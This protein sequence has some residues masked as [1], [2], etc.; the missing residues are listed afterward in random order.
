[1]T[2]QVLVTGATGF[3]GANIVD[4]LLARGLR[5]RGATRSRAKGDAMIQARPQYAGQL[6]FVLIDDFEKPGGLVE[7]VQGVDGVIHTA[8]P[9]TYD[10]TENERE[11]M[12]PAIN[13]VRAI[14]EA[15]ATNQQVKRIVLT[16]SFA[17]VLDVSRKSP[18]YFTY[19]GTDWNPL[20]YEESVDPSTSAVVAYRGSKKF[21]ELEAWR[22]VKEQKPSFDLVVLCPPM[23][24]GPVVHPVPRVD[25]LNESNAMLWNIASGANPLPVSRVP[26]WIDVRDLAVAHVEALLNQEVGGNRY[27]P[28]SPERFT[29]GLAAKIMTEEFPALQDKVVQEDQTLDDGYGLDGETAAKELGYTYR[30][31]RETV[32]DLVAQAISMSQSSQTG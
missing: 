19:T 27:V 18:P 3:I 20:T 26:F 8:S 28:A 11:L 14:V 25:S 31:F 23:T 21:A 2:R 4:A 10:T 5:V 22:Y 16:S 30:P 29:Y 15:A 12:R 13:G 9:F 7:A 1:M 32:R 6:E 17:S 24:F